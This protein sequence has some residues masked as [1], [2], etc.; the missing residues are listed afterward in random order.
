MIAENRASFTA[1]TVI[2]D[3]C[4][5]LGDVQATRLYV[6]V[7]RF[8]KHA[9][10]EVNIYMTTSI[11][12]QVLGVQNNMTVEL[13]ND[14]E[15]VCKVG[16][17]C[18]G[19]I[20][21]IGRNDKL[22]LPTTENFFQCCDC[23]KKTNEHGVVDMT[24][25]D[26]SCA[27][28]SCTFHN[29]ITNDVFTWVDSFGSHP[30]LYGY[31]PKMF[32]DTGTYRHDIDANI[33]VLS[34]GCK[35]QPGTS[36]IVEYKSGMTDEKYQLIPRKLF[37]TLKHRVAQNIKANSQPQAAEWEGRQFRNEWSMVKRTYQTY[38]LEDFLAAFRGAYHS[39]VKR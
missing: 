38:T 10:G 5:Y 21:I 23:D 30:Y 22:C 13:P 20:Q 18:H 28:D 2:R 1:D 39:S 8:L 11:K 3:I 16:I 26:D 25:C 7:A 6:P 31:A 4:L 27:C 24:S 29:V 9:L 35:V 19:E 12:S 14:V 33:L 36:I 34:G 37:N 32:T 17:C 15:V